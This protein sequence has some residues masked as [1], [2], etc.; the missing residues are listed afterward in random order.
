VLFDL[1][2][3]KQFA[4]KLNHDDNK[5]RRAVKKDIYPFIH[6]L[7]AFILEICNTDNQLE[8]KLSNKPFWSTLKD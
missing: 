5:V 6:N 8:Q 7:T 1:G 3:L 2:L 4:E